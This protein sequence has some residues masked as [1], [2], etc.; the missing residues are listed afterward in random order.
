MEDRSQPIRNSRKLV[1]LPRIEDDDLFASNCNQRPRRASFSEFVCKT[2][3]FEVTELGC[4]QTNRLPPILENG[5]KN[6]DSKPRRGSENASRARFYHQL[7]MTTKKSHQLPNFIFDPDGC[8]VFYWTCL[9]SLAVLYNYWIIIL[10]AAFQD[11]N[12]QE[13]VAYLDAVCDV[14]Y[15]SDIALQLRTGYL[16]D[17]IPIFD[18]VKLRQHYMRQTVFV[19]DVI[20]IMPMYTV[21]TIFSGLTNFS[22]FIAAS[23][24]DMSRLNRLLKFHTVYKFYDLADSRTS[25][26]NCLRAFRLSLTL[27]I[28]IHWIGCL[29]YMISEYEGLGVN[30]WV[31]TNAID[32]QRFWRKYIVCMYWS[33]M[34]LTT[35]GESNPPETDIEFIFTG[36]TFLIGVFIFATVVGN[37]GD[38]IANINATRQ[39]FQAKMDQIKIYLTHKKVPPSLQIKVKKWAEY[40]WSRTQATDE[41]RLLHM[42]PERLRAEIAVHVHLD[43]LRKVKI[44]EQCEHGFLCELVLKLKSQIYSPGDYICK[45]GETGREMYIINHGKVEVVV[46]NTSSGEEVVVA[47]LSEGNYFGEISLLRIEGVQNRRTA[48]VRSVGYSELLCL[49]RKD[50]M[51]A[52][53]EYPEAKTILESQARERIK[54]NMQAKRTFSV[55]AFLESSEETERLNG[56]LGRDDKKKRYN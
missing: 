55:D 11:V 44:F 8:I 48:D 24:V 6:L 42:L 33:A 21:T 12:K 17:G 3:G 20:A 15:L 52:L 56:R 47:L 9:T 50:L 4:E 2:T 30:N 43:T 36:L 38:V 14:I 35:I 28:V 1:R 54:T 53:V 31:Y 22:M 45:A 29:Y 41:S 25:N 27:V 51:A 37:V 26:P 5:D 18:V 16:M 19:R 46:A 39:E 10:R 49:S 7:S 34:T 23:N 40:S 13:I 32:K